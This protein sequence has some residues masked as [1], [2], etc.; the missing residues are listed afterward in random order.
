MNYKNKFT[1]NLFLTISNFIIKG[2][3]VNQSKIKAGLNT[4]AIANE[5]N[6]LLDIKEICNDYSIEKYISLLL[7]LKTCGKDEYGPK[8]LQCIFKEELIGEILYSI[9]RIVAAAYLDTCNGKLEA[10]QLKEICIQYNNLN[11]NDF[12]A[13][14]F[15]LYIE[16][17]MRSEIELEKLME[18]IIQHAK[19][20]ELNYKVSYVY[21]K[22]IS[23]RS[24][25]KKHSKQLVQLCTKLQTKNEVENFN[26]TY[27]ISGCKNSEEVLKAIH[28][29]NQG[30]KN[31]TKD[32]ELEIWCMAWGD[33]RKYIDTI[34]SISFPA[35]ARELKKYYKKDTRMKIRIYIYTTLES[36]NDV[37]Q[38]TKHL[39]DDFTVEIDTS[40]MK[41]NNVALSKRGICFVDAVARAANGKYA[42]V[43]LT[44]DSLY[45]VG[46]N[47]LLTKCPQGGVSALPT[48]KIDEENF[49]KFV[50]NNA[51]ILAKGLMTNTLLCKLYRHD[52]MRHDYQQSILDCRVT[53]A[54]ATFSP[55]S[56]ELYSWSKNCYVIK[57]DELFLKELISGCLPRYAI[58]P[59][60][61]FLNYIDHEAF[62]NCKKRNKA[63]LVE[64]S[65]E[66]IVIEPLPRN[67]YNLG[68]EKHIS[69]KSKRKKAVSVSPYKIKHCLEQ[70]T[71][72]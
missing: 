70:D 57:P 25:G 18:I 56:I 43:N 69:L 14:I 39:K 66:Y 42:I 65:D 59:C 5:Y 51:E 63:Y 62:W 67:A 41:N 28:K 19:I 33:K 8:S 45:G 36:K 10:D 40:I 31:N 61:N 3:K 46:I 34:A 27:N 71:I 58:S 52:D 47:N 1:Q 44:P 35:M 32:I 37:Q 12:L 38:S 15:A 64:S 4:L 24:I 55:E 6:H 23:M 11:L 22:A 54:Y 49:Y 48:L 16:N 17:S 13:N 7:R 2:G 30:E 9:P 21:L 72:S 20:N 26:A 50:D 60:D 53:S 68:N 29:T